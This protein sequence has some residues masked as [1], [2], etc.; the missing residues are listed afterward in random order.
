MSL[1]AIDDLDTFATTRVS[2]HAVAEHVLAA[3]RFRAEGRIGLVVTDG[4]FGTPDLGDA[5]SARVD[6]VDLVVARDGREQVSPLTTLAAA[7]AACG[8]EPGAPDVYAAETALAPDAPL[9]I[10]AVAAERLA[11]WFAFGW[12]RLAALAG[13]ETTPTL[14]PEHFDAAVELG[15]EARGQRGTFGASPGD[16][17]HSAPYLYVTHWAE[18]PSD[19]YW[20]DAAFGGASLPHGELVGSD[21]P[22]GR[23]DEFF[24]R[25]LALLRH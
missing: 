23:A 1:L 11:T 12:A 17:E 7:G 5:G 22:A 21:D 15:D 24:A 9:S 4:G 19:P 16:A 25:G 6:G 18:V 20:N 3:L 10:D 8:I 2:L 13:T 14:W